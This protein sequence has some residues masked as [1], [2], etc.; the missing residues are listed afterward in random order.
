[1]SNE[2]SVRVSMDA[3]HPINPPRDSS[4]QMQAITPSERD[5]NSASRQDESI[6]SNDV[7]ADSRHTKEAS[8]SLL[9]KSLNE[10]AQHA[11]S[12]SRG[13]KFSV[14]TEL[15]RTVITVYDTETEEVI[16]QIPS[17]EALNFARTLKNGDAALIN[18]KA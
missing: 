17:E 11:Q 15:D 8:A 10:L 7:P 9:T 12:I 6:R 1:M 16:R 14:D 18:V 3:I 13:L 4:G 5:I 2:L